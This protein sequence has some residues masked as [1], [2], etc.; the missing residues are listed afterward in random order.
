MLAQDA[1]D[2]AGRG[3]ELQRG[4]QAVDHMNAFRH[5]PRQYATDDAQQRRLVQPALVPRPELDVVID[6]AV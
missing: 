5:G 2:G 6:D 4:L 1:G 3:G